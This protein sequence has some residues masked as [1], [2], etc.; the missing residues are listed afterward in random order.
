MWTLIPLALVQSLLLAAGQVLL[1]FALN[2]MGSF[3]WS[4][5]YFGHLLTNGWLFG[6]GVCYA[7]ASLLWFYIIKHYP[8]SMAYPMISL[9]YVFGLLAAWLIFHEQVSVSAWIGVALI[10]G[11]CMLIVR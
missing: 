3:T 8:F 11:G 2:A 6:C 1:K 7:A 9:S 10:M 5:S 4:W